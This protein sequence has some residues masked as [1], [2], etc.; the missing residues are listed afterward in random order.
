LGGEKLKPSLLY[1]GVFSVIIFLFLVFF[2]FPL[3]A[4]EI[5]PIPEPAAG[6]VDRAPHERSAVDETTII[7]GEAPVAQMTNGGASIFVVIR[8]VLLLALCALAIYGVFFFVRRLAKPQEIR[9]PHLKVLARTPLSNDTFAA[10]ISIGAKAWLVGGGS[11]GINLI[12]EIS[13]NESLETML[14]DDAKRASETERRQFNFASFIRRFG[15]SQ[16][17]NSQSSISFAESL[18]KQRERIKRL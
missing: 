14:L 15:A 9:D 16:G 18:R 5:E 1:T 3:H 13:D 8:M 10:V 4:Q 17:G 7:L 2:P 12:S 6:V 11:G